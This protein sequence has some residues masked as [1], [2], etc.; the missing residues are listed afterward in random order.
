M[1]DLIFSIASTA[2]IDDDPEHD[3]VIVRMLMQRYNEEDARVITASIRDILRTRSVSVAQYIADSR[4]IFAIRLFACLT[5]QLY[6]AL[7]EY[8][9]PRE[10]LIAIGPLWKKISGEISLAR[11]MKGLN[12]K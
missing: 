10:A 9:A 1:D 6:Y 5:A 12:I 3:E 4:D 11:A 8:G 2:I 7:L